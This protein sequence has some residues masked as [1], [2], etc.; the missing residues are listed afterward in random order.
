M[1]YP[2]GLMDNN[3]RESFKYTSRGPGQ[4]TDNESSDDEHMAAN[5]L[6]KSH[7]SGMRTEPI[8]LCKCRPPMVG[9]TLAPILNGLTN[10]QAPKGL[11]EITDDSPPSAAAYTRVHAEKYMKKAADY[12]AESKA[13]FMA[14]SWLRN[15]RRSTTRTRLASTSN[16]KAK[17]SGINGAGESFGYQQTNHINNAG[18]AGGENGKKDSWE[19][20]DNIGKH[21][22]W[23]TSYKNPQVG[24][25][26]NEVRILAAYI[27]C[28]LM[29]RRSI[30][31]NQLEDLIFSI[32]GKR[33]HPGQGE[34]TE[35]SWP[36]F[37]TKYCSKNVQVVSMASNP[38]LLWK[39]EAGDEMRKAMTQIGLQCD[40]ANSSA[41]VYSNG[42]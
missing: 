19:C 37:V 4:F 24:Q 39:E 22:Q 42:F 40:G 16:F 2:S 35:E 38:I 18:F 9:K 25:V 15:K 6:V 7:A 30:S 41:P 36:A 13:R 10:P 26:P 21:L 11:V 5:H 34:F 31:V 32:Y 8:A 14:K 17:A 29:T 33:L 1:A 12:Q 27:S 3:N 23:S 28:I 20:A